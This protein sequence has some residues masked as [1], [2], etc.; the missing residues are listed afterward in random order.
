MCGH[1]VLIL[2]GLGLSDPSTVLQRGYVREHGPD[3]FYG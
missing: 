2:L 3:A 1:G